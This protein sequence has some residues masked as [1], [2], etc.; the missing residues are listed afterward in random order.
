MHT[1]L[2]LIDLA[3]TVALLC[4]PKTSSVEWESESRKLI[5]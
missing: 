4:V 5:G 1:T 3:G 2:T